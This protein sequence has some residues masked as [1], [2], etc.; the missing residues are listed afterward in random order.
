MKKL[1]VLAIICSTGIAG[2]VRTAI[3]A[4]DVLIAGRAG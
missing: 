2:Q 1:W 4:E 3:R